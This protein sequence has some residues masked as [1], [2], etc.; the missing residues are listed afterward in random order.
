MAQDL[1]IIVSGSLYT[2]SLGAFPLPY[3]VAS[4]SLGAFTG[5]QAGGSGLFTIIVSGTQYT[6]SLGAFPQ[7][8]YVATASLGSFTGSNP[9]GTQYGY[10]L[11]NFQQATSGSGGGGSNFIASQYV[12][13]GYYVAG[14]VRETW[15][16]PSINTPNPSGHPLIDII[17]M[18]S[19]PPQNSAT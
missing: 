2:G 5:S 3:Y 1:T 4:A 10:A 6:G 7:P 11:V 14:A 15:E 9:G 12:M 13:S 19:Y 18:G 17:V 8:S 16:G